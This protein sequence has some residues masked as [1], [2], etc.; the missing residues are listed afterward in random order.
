MAIFRL[1]PATAGFTADF[2]AAADAQCAAPQ[3]FEGPWP[4]KKILIYELDSLKCHQPF[5]DG[6]QGALKK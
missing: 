1:G 3:T 5:V 2:P 4:A 6:T